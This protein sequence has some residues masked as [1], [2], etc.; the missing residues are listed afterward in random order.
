MGSCGYG[1]WESVIRY[2]SSKKHEKGN[3]PS[4]NKMLNK[5]TLDVKMCEANQKQHC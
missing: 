2:T 4:G 3:N 5:N 1:V